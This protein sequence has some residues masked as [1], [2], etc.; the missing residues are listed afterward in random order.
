MFEGVSSITGLATLKPG[1]TTGQ[2]I[3]AEIS[4]GDYDNNLCIPER[5]D[6]IWGQEECPSCQNMMMKGTAC[7]EQQVKDEENDDQRFTATIH[8]KFCISCG[9]TQFLATIEAYTGY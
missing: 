7:E 1:A 2:S 8:V 9:L 5:V 6:K 4:G 3:L